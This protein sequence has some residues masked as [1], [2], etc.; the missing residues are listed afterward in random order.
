[1]R[2]IGF[3]AVLV[4]TALTGQGAPS[5]QAPGS[6]RLWTG[7]WEEQFFT[8]RNSGFTRTQ[9]QVRFRLVEGQDA[10]GA[11]R[12][13]SRTVQWAFQSETADFNSVALRDTEP[14]ARGFRQQRYR[15]DTR[16]TCAGGGSVELGEGY[17]TE[18]LLVPT[19]A[20]REQ[21]RPACVTETTARDTGETIRTTSMGDAVGLPGVPGADQLE[22][23]TFN[24]SWHLEQSRGYHDG[25]FSVSVS[26]AVPATMEVSRGVD[27]PYARFVPAPG[28]TL[29]FT[30]TAPVG[31]ARFRFELDSEGTSRFPGYATNARVDEAFFAR[32][33]DGVGH[34]RGQYAD[35]GPDVIFDPR[36]FGSDAW[37]RIEPLVVETREPQSVAMATVTAMDHGAVGR[38]RAYVKSEEC[39]D[40]QPVTIRIGGEQR[41]AISIPL[42]EDNNLMADALEHY[43]GIDSGADQDAEPVGSG[44]AGDGLTAFEEY[45]GFLVRGAACDVHDVTGS[46]SAGASDEHIRSVPHHKNLF[47][48]TPDADLVAMLEG[49]GWSSGLSVHPICEPHYVDNDTRIV[50][51][52]LQDAGV[53]TWQGHTVSQHEPQHGV[54]VQ[55]VEELDGLGIAR[56]VNVDLMGPPKL[57]KV[58]EIRKPAAPEGLDRRQA[59][60]LRGDDADPEEL[61]WT[62]RHELGHA[63]GIPHHSDTVQ[64]WRLLF[65]KLNVTT[66]L[67]PLQGDGGPPDF[68]ILGSGGNLES[69]AS[70]SL[71]VGA[72]LECREGDDNVVYDADRAFAGCLTQKIVRRGQQN[73]GDQTCPMRYGGDDRDFYEAPGSIARFLGNREVVRLGYSNYQGTRELGRLWVDEWSGRFLRYQSQHER[74]PLGHFCRSV[75]GTGINALPGDRNHAGDAGRDKPCL[76]YLV[77][78]DVAARGVP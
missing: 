16:T 32:Y 10:S 5:A 61:A 75:T 73:S 25:S 57:T 53:R 14:D 77:V 36:H 40:W 9:T 48:Q 12:W 56:P 31:T 51:F 13:V 1:M 30:A 58:I 64:D 67:S 69:L 45:R 72:G 19:D 28:Q 22:G 6:Q 66:M 29:T 44:T 47:V 70:A 8:E 23:C 24:E 62:L 54:W 46:G 50:N 39:G 52:T 20:Q 59:R 15:Q 38:L 26:G 11:S 41:D 35:D 33:E 65:G 68:S 43:R 27:E 37:S 76:D 78:N 21:L 7:A 55:A 18:T 60:W 17:I 2:A 71:L 63:V 4:F 49:F 3:T 34:L 42:D 74:P